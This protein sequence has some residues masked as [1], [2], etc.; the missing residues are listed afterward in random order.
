MLITGATRGIGRAAATELARMGATVVVHGRDAARVEAV[1]RDIDAAANAQRAF[2]LVADLSSQAEVRRLAADVGQRFPRLDVLINNA[3]GVTKGRTTTVDGLE[4]QLAVN[5][6]A[7]FLLTNLLIGKLKACAPA[8]IVTVA[9]NAHR[10]AAF[11]LEDLNWERRRYNVFGAYGATKLANVLFTREL[12]RRLAGIG[13]T[14][15]CLHPGVVATHI[16]AG[17]GIAGAAIGLVGK[18]FMLSKE[19]GAATTVYLASSDEV[20]GVSG[21]YFDKCRAV[22]PSR[23]AQ[24]DA[25][26]RA[27]WARSEELV[28]L[29]ESLAG[30]A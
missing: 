26:A 20:A 17:A 7:P 19:E 11:D 18:V 28:G 10:R 27:L 12:A 14:A 21:R 15:N 9:S 16:F 2:G 6:L 8:R 30:S 5:H 3:G 22:E 13:V 29:T 1:C 24:D 23:R 4:T 25:L